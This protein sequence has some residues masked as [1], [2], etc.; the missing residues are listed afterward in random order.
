MSAYWLSQYMFDFANYLVPGLLAMAVLTLYGVHQLLGIEPCA[1]SK[2]LHVG[3][4]D[5]AAG[6]TVLAILLYGLSVIP[7]TYVLSFM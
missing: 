3:C 2:S 7:F 4:L 1:V 6:A 5:D